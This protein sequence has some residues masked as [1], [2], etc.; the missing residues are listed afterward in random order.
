MAAGKPVIGTCFGGTPE[1][2]LDG[3]TGTIIN[4]ENIDEFAEAILELLGDPEKRKR[5]GEAG[6]N[7]ISDNFSLDEQ[8]RRYLNLFDTSC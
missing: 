5:M 1:A 8:V 7:R 3:E 6:R 2:V 4:P